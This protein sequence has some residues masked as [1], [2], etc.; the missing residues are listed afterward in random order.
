MDE[1]MKVESSCCIATVRD[2]E[3][4]CEKQKKMNEIPGSFDVIRDGRRRGE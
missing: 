1:V 3:V 4:C 2:T